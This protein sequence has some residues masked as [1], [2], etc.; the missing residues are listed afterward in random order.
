M[1][2]LAGSGRVDAALLDNHAG[3]LPAVLAARVEL[4][5]G[6]FEAAM[7]S[8]ALFRDQVFEFRGAGS[9]SRLRQALTDSISWSLESD[10]AIVIEIASSGGGQTRRLILAPREVPHRVF[11][12]NL[13]AENGHVGVHGR[14]AEELAALHFAAYY[15]LLGEKPKDRPVPERSSARTVTPATGMMGPVYCPAALLVRE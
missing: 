12:S 10:A 7:P 6:R 8:Q 4:D 1:R 3:R 15:E 9:E 5:G 2:R 11:V 13:P 14:A